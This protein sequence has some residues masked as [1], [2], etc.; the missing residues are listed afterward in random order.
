ML[1]SYIVSYCN[2]SNRVN[3][4]VGER[5]LHVPFAGPGPAPPSASPP[6]S[7]TPPPSTVPLLTQYLQINGP[8]SDDFCET[9]EELIT[10]DAADMDDLA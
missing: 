7:P 1:G 5:H 3:L 8:S 6:S 4:E 9:I 10:H 2:L